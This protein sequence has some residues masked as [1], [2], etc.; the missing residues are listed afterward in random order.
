MMAAMLELDQILRANELSIS[1]MA[2]VP[3]LLLIMLAANTVYRCAVSQA[4]SGVSM[5]RTCVYLGLHFFVR[6]S[7]RICSLALIVLG[8]SLGCGCLAARVSSSHNAWVACTLLPMTLAAN[9][10]VPVIGSKC[11]RDV[12]QPGARHAGAQHGV[13]ASGRFSGESAQRA[14]PRPQV[15]ACELLL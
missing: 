3:S 12:Y 13:R 7:C 6:I 4:Y 15:A 14:R 11:E 5:L 10:G 8:T 2:A 9:T 1:L